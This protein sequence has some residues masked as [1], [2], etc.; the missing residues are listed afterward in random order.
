MLERWCGLALTPAPSAS[1]QR[2]KGCTRQHWRTV[3]NMESLQMAFGCSQLA[4]RGGRLLALES[5][6]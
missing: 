2:H 1:E 3:L 4:C 6:C 5:L